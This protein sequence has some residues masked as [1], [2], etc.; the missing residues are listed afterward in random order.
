VPVVALVLLV[1][2]GRRARIEEASGA[3][4]PSLAPSS[5]PIAAAAAGDANATEAS[6]SAD[7]AV[8]STGAGDAAAD[9]VA[10]QLQPDGAVLVDLNAATEADLR[11]LPG[12]GP[13]RARAILELRVKLG[14]FKSVEELARIKG[15]G[16]KSILKLRPFVRV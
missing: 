16:R 4:V 11:R 10:L 13:S 5:P 2:V 6:A 8:P 14:R 15:F 7:A 9:T 3:P 1:I 12:V